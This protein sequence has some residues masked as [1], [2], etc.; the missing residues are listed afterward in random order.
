MSKS[1]L[2]DT[3][4]KSIT[5]G[6]G[7]SCNL[8]TQIQ[9]TKPNV[10]RKSRA[11]A[12]QYMPN[13]KFKKKTQAEK[14]AEAIGKVFEQKGVMKDIK[15]LS[16]NAVKEVVKKANASAQADFETPENRNAIKNWQKL[17]KDLRKVKNFEHVISTDWGKLDEKEEKETPKLE[18]VSP[19]DVFKTPV[20][21]SSAKKKKEKAR[22]AAKAETPSRSTS[23]LALSGLTRGMRK[24]LVPESPVK[25][26]KPMFKFTVHDARTG[27][28]LAREGEGAGLVVVAPPKPHKHYR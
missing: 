19:I 16:D 10:S 20:S 11:K 27:E 9:K 14:I 8:K 12:P 2:V 18:P 4:L 23:V 13:L 25:P 3:L 15:K 7:M 5:S 26:S 28:S 6:A 24:T 17:A 1:D 22:K 21:K